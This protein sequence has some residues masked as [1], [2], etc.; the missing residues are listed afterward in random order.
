MLKLWQNLIK[1]WMVLE[2]FQYEGFFGKI[3]LYLM[4]LVSGKFSPKMKL[5]NDTERE[6]FAKRAELEDE[7]I[8]S[9]VNW[10]S[11]FEQSELSFPSEIDIKFTPTLS[12]QDLLT[13]LHVMILGLRGFVDSYEEKNPKCAM[14]HRYYLLLKKEIVLRPNLS[15]MPS[16]DGFLYY[17][18]SRTERKEQS[19]KLKDARKSGSM[20]IFCESENIRSNGNMWSCLDCGKS[21]RKESN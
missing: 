4:G 12:N 21:F 1:N 8:Q 15:F 2:M 7:I 17:L 11:Y 19:D 10:F 16:E 13:M 14:L 20:C 3:M 9:G 18:E 5:E 6:Y